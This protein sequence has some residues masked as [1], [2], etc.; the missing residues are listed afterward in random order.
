MNFLSG[1]RTQ[2]EKDDPI[3]HRAP[4]Y[5]AAPENAETQ[6]DRPRFQRGS[7]LGRMPS[8]RE[9]YD[10]DTRT[11]DSEFGIHARQPGGQGEEGGSLA[12]AMAR[13]SSRRQGVTEKLANGLDDYEKNDAQ[14]RKDQQDVLRNVQDGHSGES[15]LE[16]QG[17]NQRTM[18]IEKQQ[19]DKSQSS[20][21]SGPDDDDSDKNLVSWDTP[22]SL[23]NPRNWSLHRR[24]AVIAIVSSYTFLS[25]LSSSMIA[26]ALPII[27]QQFNITS[28]VEQ[29][30]M[31]SVFVLAYAIGPMFLGPCSEMFGRR[32]VLQ[33]S[34]LFFIIFT[35]ACA[36]AQNRIQLSIFRFFAGFG[37]SA[38]MSI[39]GGTVSDL[40]KPEERGTAMSVYS[41]APLLGPAV[42][43]IVGA[44]I[45]EYTGNWRWIFGVA[46]IAE[47]VT[48]IVGLMLLPE[49][50]APQL[51]H[52]KAERLRRETGNHKL[53][54]IF[55]QNDV[56]WLTRFEH[57]MI[58]PFV[59]IGTQP[60]MQSLALFMMVSLLNGIKNCPNLLLDYLWNNVHPPHRL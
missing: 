10:A 44:F 18:D 15:V 40:M 42:G 31:L 23:E 56:H 37:G 7:K 9:W 34:N 52:K 2:R 4:V 13:T 5:N 3:P 8:H 22:D 17:N 21:S 57:N 11:N 49:T 30:L 27:S 51:L 58:R 14:V 35:V 28:S 6:E 25:P 16:A 50:Y 19:T 60:I 26:P 41:L 39:G 36:V 46:S 33:L 12:L 38:P 59:L 54:T 48:A 47:G 45:I 20:S 29:S 53:H 24:W 55:E 32:I 43:P 1:K